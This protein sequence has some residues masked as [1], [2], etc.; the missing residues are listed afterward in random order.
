LLAEPGSRFSRSWE[1]S[2]RK[3]S[4][5]WIG[6]VSQVR[7]PFIGRVVSHNNGAQRWG[8]GGCQQTSGWRVERFCRTDRCWNRGGHPGNGR[9][10]RQ[11]V[12]EYL[13]GPNNVNRYFSPF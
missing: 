4:G 2:S 6:C 10:R 9:L 5:Q 1:L 8:P 12:W 7:H 3:F 13:N 11:P